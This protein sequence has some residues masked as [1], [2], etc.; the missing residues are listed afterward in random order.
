VSPHTFVS[1]MAQYSPQH[2]ACRY[3]EINRT[4]T[5][6][7]YDEVLDDVVNLGLENAFIQELESPQ[8]YLPDFTRDSPF[9]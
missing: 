3:P 9:E 7:E 1:V 4:L 6:E 8:H 2:K 5:K